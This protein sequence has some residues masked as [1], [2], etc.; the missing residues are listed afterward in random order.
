MDE[1][2]LAN[3]EQYMEEGYGKYSIKDVM[4]AVNGKKNAAY[5]A[6]ADTHATHQE[7]HVLQICLWFAE[8]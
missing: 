3:L 1:I 2:K 6:Q 8:N 7:L 4:D 5:S